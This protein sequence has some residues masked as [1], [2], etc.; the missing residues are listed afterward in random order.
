MDGAR[1]PCGSCRSTPECLALSSGHSLNYVDEGTGPTLLFVHGTPTWSHEW[2]HLVAAR[3]PR[4]RSVASDH[5]GF[6]HSD[7]PADGDYTPTA[8]PCRLR[9]FVERLDLRDVTLIVHGAGNEASSTIMPGDAP[10]RVRGPIWRYR[11]D[12]LG[13][14]VSVRRGDPGADTLIARY[15]YDVLGRRIVKRVYSTASG[16]T[17]GYLRMVYRGSH[18]GFETDS[19]GT[20]GLTYTWGTGTDQLLAITDGATHYYAT[21]DR[22]GSVRSLAKRDGTWALTQRF[23]PYGV[24]MSRDTSASFGLGTRLRY[25]WTGREWDQETGLSYHRARYLLPTIRRWTQEDPIGY[26]GGVNVY[27]Y[28]GGAALEAKDPSGLRSDWGSSFTS[29]TAEADARL[30]SLIAWG[31]GV[32]RAWE[33]RGGGGSGGGGGGLVATVRNKDGTTKEVACRRMQNACKQWLED[34][35][36][37]RS[38]TA[39]ERSQLRD[40][41]LEIN[42]SRVRIFDNVGGSRGLALGY[43]IYLPDKGIDKLAHEMVHVVQY[44]DWGPVRYYLRGTWEQVRDRAHVWFGIG[45]DP[46]HVPVPVPS[47]RSYTS[48]GM[49]QQAVITGRCFA[50]GNPDA[51]D[52]SPF[53]P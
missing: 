16:G 7:R 2:R 9:E 47:G 31:E 51:C 42:C 41:C 29:P 25:G 44:A 49:E 14:L 34:R 48:W 27:A 13:R 32:Y 46:Y 45:S 12:A 53:R 4:Y 43:D 26:A 15:A 23:S 33:E 18:V 24:R 5:L 36:G 52:A 35:G 22:L 21:T 30:A 17:L 38:L 50:G 8:H 3:S 28:V 39:D 37:A 19:G 6:G 10:R 11:Y 1:L 40:F 20:I